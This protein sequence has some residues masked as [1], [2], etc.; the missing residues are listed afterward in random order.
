[1]LLLAA[2]L[3][4]RPAVPL[5]RRTVPPFVASCAAVRLF[6]VTS[7]AVQAVVSHTLLA[8]AVNHAITL[9]VASKLA[10]QQVRPGLSGTGQGVLMEGWNYPFRK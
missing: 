6:S 7:A 1:M 2:A 5:F 8:A 3:L 9:M 4:L 10:R